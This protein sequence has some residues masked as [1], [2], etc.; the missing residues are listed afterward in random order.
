MSSTDSLWRKLLKKKTVTVSLLFLVLLFLVSILSYLVIPDN[1]PNANDQQLEIALKKPGFS[2]DLLK[3]PI[4]IKPAQKQKGLSWIFTGKQRQF[5]EVPFASAEIENN[6]I[7]LTNHYGQQK[8]YDKFGQDYLNEFRTQRTY[9]LGTDRYGRDIFS[10][11]ILGIRVSLMI[12][13]MSVLLS[14]VIG[15]IIGASGGY[16]GG[17]VDRVAMYMINVTWSIPT[18]LLVFAIVIAFGRGMGIIFLAVGLTLW[19]DVARIVRGQVLQIKEKEYILATQSLSYSTPR[20]I[21]SHI[22]PNIVGPLLVIAATNFAVAILIEAGLSY[23]GFGIQP[24]SPSV[25]NMLNENYGYAISGKPFLAIIPA[26]TIMLMVLAFNLVGSG[27]RDILD[28]KS[29]R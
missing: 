24:P 3:F 25:G 26:I 10:R 16:Y 23:L 17:W 22:L 19:V 20:I 1:T 14:L 2:T 7:V 28:V 4:I 18:L 9:L 8:I 15:I 27:L 5:E 29:T 12:G 13:F 11:L 6:T 21:T